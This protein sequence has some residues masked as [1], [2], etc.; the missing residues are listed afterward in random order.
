M[1]NTLGNAPKI[2]QAAVID[3]AAKHI[4]A[5][6]LARRIAEGIIASGI[7]EEHAAKIVEEQKAKAA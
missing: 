1:K 2:N 6:I 5:K 4:L 7:I 3:A